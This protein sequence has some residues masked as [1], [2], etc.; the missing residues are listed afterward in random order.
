MSGTSLGA[1]ANEAKCWLCSQTARG[2][3]APGRFVYRHPDVVPPEAVDDDPDMWWKCLDC[4]MYQC[5]TTGSL[6]A[7]ST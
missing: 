4:G 5:K 1:Q 2:L 6:L 3:A 7:A